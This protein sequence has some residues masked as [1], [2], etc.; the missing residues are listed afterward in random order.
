MIRKNFKAMLFIS[1]VIPFSVLLTPMTS[2]SHALR[3]ER[4]IVL[5]ENQIQNQPDEK[6]RLHS[7]SA[8]KSP[9]T[10]QAEFVNPNFPNYQQAFVNVSFD[11]VVRLS[12]RDF[13]Y[14]QVNGTIAF[15]P[16]LLG[17]DPWV[18]LVDEPS[19]PRTRFI[20]NITAGENKTITWKAIPIRYD[21]QQKNRL[22]RF[23]ATGLMNGQIP[24]SVTIPGHLIEIQRPIMIVEGPYPIEKHDNAS[25][26]L[27]YKKSKHLTLN[28]TSSINST[29]NLTG[30]HVN[31][32]TDSRLEAD[33]NSTEIETLAP[34][35][36][37]LYNFSIES[38]KKDEAESILEIQVA[39]NV[40]PTVTLV[41]IIS[42]LKQEDEGFGFPA[43]EALFIFIGAFLVISYSKK[44]KHK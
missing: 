26:E 6:E 44:R 33:F 38:V 10:L 9:S 17:A 42:V 31:I 11:I 27:K 12:A 7:L 37:Y 43:L 1:F 29:F 25:Y 8:F 40:T 36:F 22:V 13:D 3:V 23:N 15:D 34:G 5:K 18:V 30:V 28:I 39:S 20:G 35:E 41:L 4:Q 24:R 2:S 14:T 21:A 19:N 16:H 32:V